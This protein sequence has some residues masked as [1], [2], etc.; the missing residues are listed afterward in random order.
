[1][2]SASTYAAIL[3]QNL[4]HVHALTNMQRANG[5]DEYRKAAADWIPALED[6]FSALKRELKEPRPC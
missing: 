5:N 2:E 1:M 6:Q 4:L 3:I